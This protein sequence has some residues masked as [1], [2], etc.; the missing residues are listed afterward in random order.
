MTQRDINDLMLAEADYSRYSIE[1]D[2]YNEHERNI[3]KFCALFSNQLN[4]LASFEDMFYSISDFNG[5]TV[6]FYS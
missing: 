5:Y 4:I 2:I 1:D 6:I 3:M